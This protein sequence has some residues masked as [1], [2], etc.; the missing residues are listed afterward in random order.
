MD[1]RTEEHKNM[2]KNKRPLVIIGIVLVLCLIAAGIFAM[3]ANSAERRLSDQLELGRKYLE[4]MD[5]EQAI[6][7][8]E[9]AISI[10]PKCEEAY[11]SLAD[12][13]VAQGTGDAGVYLPGADIYV[14]QEYVEKAMEILEEGYSQTGSETISTRLDELRDCYQAG[15][16]TAGNGQGTGSQET[17][18]SQGTD[19][20]QTAGSGQA[21]GG[22]EAGDQGQAVIDENDPFVQF[23]N[24]PFTDENGFGDVTSLDAAV[25]YAESNGF[26]VGTFDFVPI[27]DLYVYYEDAEYLDPDTD[28][29][30]VE[31]FLRVD[32]T[33]D[34][35]DNG[36]SHTIYSYGGNEENLTC[37]IDTWLGDRDTM[38]GETVPP[39][40]GFAGFLA[41]HE[42]L[43]VESILQTIGLGD[44]E[45]MA[46]VRME[47]GDGEYQV[48]TPYGT[49]DVYLF[50]YA[51]FELEGVNRNLKITFQEDSGAPWR[52]I[53]LYEG[54][55]QSLAASHQN[56]VTYYFGVSAS[57]QDGEGELD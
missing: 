8:F 43:T 11:L 50:S 26:V 27:G 44:E 31:P 19:G 3:V 25:K 33:D 10:D 9:A 12:I 15:V 48:E 40:G 54:V 6:V 18:N 55:V 28:E 5:Y 52:S 30:V 21:S 51:A 38:T 46:H 45:F 42:C 47:N 20:G 41:E 53:I 2:K 57:T 16:S 49:A 39:V 1:K 7:A 56:D 34:I 13:Y 14:A 29:L 32:T 22:S 4:E 24:A 36:G 17:N 37:S 35:F 23:L